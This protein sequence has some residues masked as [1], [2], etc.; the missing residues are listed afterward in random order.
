[1]VALG[2]REMRETQ[3]QPAGF[4]NLMG[5][6]GRQADGRQS[7]PEVRHD[8][9]PMEKV[10]SPPTPLTNSATLAQLLHR[11]T[12]FLLGRVGTVMAG[13]KLRLVW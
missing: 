5:Q 4:H 12:C 2:S 10:W 9:V 11:Q 8:Y 3:P 7:S 6:I 13:A 1:M